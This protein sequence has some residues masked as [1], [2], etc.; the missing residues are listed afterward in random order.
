M[1]TKYKMTKKELQNKEKD[2]EKSEKELRALRNRYAVAR[3]FGTDRESGEMNTEMLQTYSEFAPVQQRIAEL[4]D[5]IEN[6]EIVEVKDNGKVGYGAVVVLKFIYSENDVDESK[7][8]ISSIGMANAKYSVC[9]PSSPLFSFIEG[10]EK[11]FKGTFKS[12]SDRISIE[13]D[14]EIL[15]VYYPVDLE[16]K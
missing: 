4:K 15:D 7:L 6:A 11:G 5:E 3:T 14:L 16:K 13:Y 10:K 2:L 12:E 8:F 1:L 9:T